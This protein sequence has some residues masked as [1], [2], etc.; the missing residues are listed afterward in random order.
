MIWG[1]IFGILAISDPPQR[2]QS[3]LSV[4]FDISVT[5]G[6]V[7]CVI[8]DLVYGGNT[9]MTFPAIYWAAKSFSGV[10]GLIVSEANGN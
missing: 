1:A 9:G 7:S 8:A 2:P 3:R 4:F 10:V 5:V 6:L